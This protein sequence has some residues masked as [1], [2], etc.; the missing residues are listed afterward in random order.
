MRTKVQ[1]AILDERQ[2]SLIRE[3]KLR[4]KLGRIAL[5]KSEAAL[6]ERMES[7]NNKFGLLKEQAGEFATKSDLKS[8]DAQVSLLTKFVY[9][10]IGGLIVIDLAIKYFAH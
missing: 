8:I 3:V 10:G 5:E 6:F 9:I 4:S 2:K 1:L 7:S